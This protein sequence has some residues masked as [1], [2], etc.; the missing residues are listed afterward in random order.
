M[1][2]NLGIIGVSVFAATFTI[3]LVVAHHL[4][5]ATGPKLPQPFVPVIEQTE[6]T[7]LALPVP[8]NFPEPSFWMYTSIENTKGQTIKSSDWAEVEAG[9]SYRAITP[10]LLAPGLYNIKVHLS[11]QQNWLKWYD[12]SFVLSVLTVKRKEAI[13]GDK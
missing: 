11:Y 8:T 1:S 9:T 10:S 7:A 13:N 3:V 4:S 12:K 5:I 2:R 6:G